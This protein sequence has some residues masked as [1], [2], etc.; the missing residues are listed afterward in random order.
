MRF[1][2]AGIGKFIAK[3]ILQYGNRY[4]AFGNSPPKQVDP[5]GMQD[6]DTG[7][8]D[9]Q[10]VDAAQQATVAATELA[11]AG[12]GM[13]AEVGG[14]I[15]AIITENAAGI[16]AQ[17]G[18][19][20][21]QQPSWE[22]KPGWIKTPSG[23]YVPPGYVPPLP[24]KPYAP[25]A[26]KPKPGI[27]NGEVNEKTGQV[28]KAPWTVPGIP[29]GKMATWADLARQFVKIRIMVKKKEG[30]T[31]IAGG[32]CTIGVSVE[33]P[34]Y[35][36]YPHEGSLNAVSGEWELLC[37]GSP[38]TVQRAGGIAGSS[39]KGKSLGTVW[40]RRATGM[41]VA[42][43]GAGELKVGPDGGTAQIDGRTGTWQARLTVG[44]C[45]KMSNTITITP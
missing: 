19:P 4:R 25:V 30:T 6:V 39:E 18:A 28:M 9:T 34:L 3:D 45:V 5:L 13:G 40:K 15:A 44:T 36:K 7:Q 10:A 14:K 38:V 43:G 16:G 20:A 23:K 35:E 17:P 41:E 24:K 33:F 32:A 1:Y 22:P 29:P 37:N 31:S 26:P 12:L 27:L 42:F 2:H 21:S 8:K 11:T